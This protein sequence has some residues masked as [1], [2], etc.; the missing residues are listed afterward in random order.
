M[1]HKGAGEQPRTTL[2]HRGAEVQ[3]GSRER[4]YCA[5][6]DEQRRTAIL[7]DEQPMTILQHS[8]AGEQPQTVLLLRGAEEQ[9]RTTLL[10][11]SQGRTL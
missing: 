7:P 11:S 2:L 10:H 3:A 6:G 9:P 4:P 8:G 1:P 5:G